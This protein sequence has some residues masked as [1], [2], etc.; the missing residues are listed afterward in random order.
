[1]R[2]AHEMEDDESF[3][4]F[5]SHPTTRS[6][7]KQESHE[8]KAVNWMQQDL[9]DCLEG[10]VR[11]LF[12]AKAELR[13]TSTYFPFTHP[14][15]ELEIKFRNQWLEL[16]GCGIMEQ[17]LL[18][19]VGIDD[20]IGW[21]FGIGLERLAMR[22]YEIPDIRLFWSDDSGFLSQFQVDNIRK[23][24]KYKPV[25]QFPQCTNDISFWIPEKFE[26]NDFY[27]LVR[28]CGGDLVEQVKLIDEFVHP[29]SGRRSVCFKIIYRHMEKTLTKDE[30]NVLHKKIADTAVQD[31]NVE[32]R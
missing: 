19:S 5:E 15:W 17:K 22:L 32:I 29:K 31:L 13:W 26:K 28:N 12:G 20:Q 25:S 6:P 23:V 1:M 16:L 10:A 11:S 27:E 8:Q 2:Y 9:K 30:A 7:T 18:N 4:L 21:A 14:S 24:V 3:Q